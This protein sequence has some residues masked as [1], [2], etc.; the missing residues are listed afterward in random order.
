MLNEILDVAKPRPVAMYRAPP[1]V[2]LFRMEW[3]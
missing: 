1:K 2:K 3:V